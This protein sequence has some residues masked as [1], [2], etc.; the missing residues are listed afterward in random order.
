MTNLIKK[1]KKQSIG[2]LIK[3]SKPGDSRKLWSVLNVKSKKGS[4]LETPLTAEEL[5]NHFSSIADNLTRGFPDSI[6]RL[7]PYEGR[8]M[9]EFPK[10]T[11][12]DVIRY[13]SSIPDKKATGKDGISVAM[14][15]KTLPFT[16]N[17]LT[18]T[19]FNVTEY[20]H[21]AGKVRE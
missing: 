12:H 15:K 13:L 19:G 11:P 8:Q 20:S 17:V 18:E 2:Q 3:T 16:L 1:K 4:S 14:L 5:N 9:S 6:Q 21:P 10:F 7:P